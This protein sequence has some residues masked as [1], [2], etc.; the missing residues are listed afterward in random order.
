[1]EISRQCAALC[2][3]SS[4][5]T[6]LLSPEAA[7]TY[8]GLGGLIETLKISRQAAAAPSAHGTNQAVPRRLAPLWLRRPSASR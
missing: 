6:R 1:V 7:A 4:G 8:L 5:A 3:S 2:A